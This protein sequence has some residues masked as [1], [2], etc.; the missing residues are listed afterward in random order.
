MARIVRFEPFTVAPRRPRPAFE[1]AFDRMV[2]DTLGLAPR[3][4]EARRPGLTSNLYET[5]SGYSV[6]LPLPGV[7]AED[8]E[9]SVQENLLALKVKRDWST[10][11]KARVLWQGFAS[12]AWQQTFTL[13]G[14]VDAEHVAAHLEDG[15]LRLHLPKAAH[16]RPRQ[17]KV[18]AGGEAVKP[19]E[20]SA[21][22]AAAAAAAT[23]APE[24]AG[25]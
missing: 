8:V 20:D 15:V 7:K 1:R 23:T 10:P 16:A 9:I 17:I 5:E 14:E 12:G 24:T 13:P 11:E 25:A 18:Q 22:A 21:P 6:E 4:A 3:Y 19:I 2:L